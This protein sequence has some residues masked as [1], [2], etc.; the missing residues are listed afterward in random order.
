MFQSL[1][2]CLADYN[3][4]IIFQGPKYQAFSEKEPWYY[5]PFH[6]CAHFLIHSFLYF[7][8]FVCLA[9]LSILIFL[10]SFLLQTIY[11]P[12]LCT[13]LLQ[14]PDSYMPENSD[15]SQ[16]S[17]PSLSPVPLLFSGHKTSLQVLDDWKHIH[18]YTHTFKNHLIHS[19]IIHLNSGKLISVYV[20]FS[21]RRLWGSRMSI[22]NKKT[23]RESAEKSLHCLSLDKPILT[24]P[25]L[26]LFNQLY[27]INSIS[28][29][30]LWGIK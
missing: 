8:F 22:A 26:P 24:F 19:F 16:K 17:M 30:L 5:Q 6:S 23:S 12:T 2:K 27:V 7:F 25:I 9:F 4:N 14:S 18:T 3:L 28:E 20:L 10:H 15:I 13:P 29:N 1:I 11:Q 21:F